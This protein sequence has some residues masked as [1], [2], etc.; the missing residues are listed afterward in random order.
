MVSR[1]QGQTKR[2]N[3][4]GNGI[5]LCIGRVDL[6]VF[7]VGLACQKTAAVQRMHKF[8]LNNS[9]ALHTIEKSELNLSTLGFGYVIYARTLCR[10]DAELKQTIQLSVTNS[11]IWRYD[12]STTANTA[13]SHHNT[14]NTVPMPNTN[15]SMN[16][17]EMYFECV[18]Q[19]LTELCC[20]H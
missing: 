16:I 7:N 1:R 19:F 2:L 8:A 14:I 13:T 15:L 17:I 3:S 20:A 12:V 18:I 11:G 9:F 4:S 5:S 6:V 10:C